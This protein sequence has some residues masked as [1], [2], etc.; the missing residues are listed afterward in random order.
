M[1]LKAQRQD[2]LLGSFSFSFFWLYS[3]AVAAVVVVVADAAYVIFS[4]VCVF[5]S[6]AAMMDKLATSKCFESINIHNAS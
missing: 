4:P 6:S 2:L 5:T 3:V 1:N